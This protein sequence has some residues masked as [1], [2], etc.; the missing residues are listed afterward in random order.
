MAEGIHV[1]V[2]WAA[3]GAERLIDLVVPQGSSLA[4]AVRLSGL[5]PLAG[6]AGQVS[7]KLGVWG[8]LKPADSPA[9]AGDRIE[10]YRPLVADPKAARARR[11]RKKAG[12][13]KG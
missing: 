10:I 2:A 12:T 5:D 11:A 9:C 6:T 4:A 3:P 8:K 7:A 13:S 1:T